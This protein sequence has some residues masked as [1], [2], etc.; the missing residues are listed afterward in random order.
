[1]KLTSIKDFNM[2]VLI[3]S[4][5]RR[6]YLV[7]YF[8]DAVGKDGK[9]VVTNSVPGS[10]AM[11]LGTESYIVPDVF[12]EGCI[13]S[14]LEIIE[15][16]KIDIQFSLHDLENYFL[17]KNLD[18]FEGSGAF[19]GVSSNF[20]NHIAIDKYKTYEFLTGKDIPAVPAYLTPGDFMNS[21]HDF[22][23]IV[24]PRYGFGSSYIF[25][26]RDKDELNFIYKYINTRA[27]RKVLEYMEWD[28][29]Y[30]VIIQP[31]VNGHEYGLEVANSLDMEYVG[32]FQ[33]R[34]LGMRAGE[35]DGAEFLDDAE[36]ES[37]ARNLSDKLHHVCLLD[38][39][40]FKTGDGYQ[41][42]ELNPQVWRAISVF[43]PFG[44]KFAGILPEKPQGRACGI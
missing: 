6:S 30:P 4:V 38:T 18:K 15:K 3:T 24:K 36:L 43:A 41:I 44:R 13:D 37:L 29:E 17:S 9:V 23:V 16:E 7:K 40:I 5:G 1:M 8:L 34:K 28:T 27:D 12:S 42:L 35:T 19:M 21:G 2:N 33:K 11:Q 10:P 26:A 20:V 39:D 32:C 22:P 14:I 25:E 31:K